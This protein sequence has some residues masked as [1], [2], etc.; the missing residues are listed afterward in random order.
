MALWSELCQCYS[1]L[2]PNFS[3]MLLVL[4]WQSS[5]GLRVGTSDSGEPHRSFQN[6][7]AQDCRA[8]SLSLGS[9]DL[10]HDGESWLG[11]VSAPGAIEKHHFICTHGTASNIEAKLF[12]HRSLVHTRALLSRM[13]HSRP[14]H[15]QI[16]YDADMRMPGRSLGKRLPLIL[17]SWSN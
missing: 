15:I 1:F 5:P 14:V 9:E 7:S 4:Y 13:H 12:G 16:E 8:Q 6:Q 11:R 2:K 10:P 3:V 17:L